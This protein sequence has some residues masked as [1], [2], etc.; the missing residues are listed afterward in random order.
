MNML[1]IRR[2]FIALGVLLLLLV[3]AAVVLVTTFDANRYKGL[4][5]DW[6]KTERQRTL[7]IDGPI[8]LSVFPRLAIKVSKVRL[9]EHA[10]KDEFLAIDEAA[11]AVE[12]LP[13]LR[14]QVVVDRVSARG[15]RAVY[16]RDAKGARNIDDLVG[17]GG[18]AA[19]GAPAPTTGGGTAVRFDVSAVKLD[20]VQLRLRDAMA[21]LDGTVALQSFS[22]GRLANQAES[23]VSLRAS[24]QLT[25]PQALKAA[26][27]GDTKLALDL[28]KNA[29][30][31]RD[32]KLDVQLD[33]T[34]AKNLALTATGAL[35]W[36]GTALRAGPLKL[37]LKGA[38]FGADML[39][40]STLE[41]KQLLFN[42]SGQRLE[43]DALRVALAGRHGADMPFDVALDWPQLAVDAQSLKGSALS[44]QVKT[45]GP[46]ALTG[47]FRSGAPSGKFEALRL[48]GVTLTLQGQM[49]QRKIDGTWKSD[50]VVNAGRGAVAL[51]AI[52]LKATLSDPGLQPLQL[53]VRGKANADAKAAS[54]TLD[55]ALSGNKFDSSGQAALGGAVPNIKANAR[56]DSLD[57][58][59]VLAPDKPAAAN[60]AA[61][62]GPAPAD[63]PVALDGLNAV[64]GQFNFTAGALAFRQ[65]RVND[66]KVD[67]ALDGG[68]LRIAKL[69][70]RAWGGAIDGSG[71]AEAKSHRVAVKLAADGVDVN[72]L[73]K[74]VAGK[75]LLEGTGRVTADV[76][77]AGATVGA[78]RSA[79]AGNVAL[80]VRDGAVKGVNLARMLRQ[81]KAALAMKTDAMTQANATEKTDFSELSATAR[82]VNGVATSD[83]LDV[84]S[85]FLRIGG[86]GRFDIGRG[87][88]DYTAKATVI[89]SPTGQD[90]AEL[91][92]LKGVTVP[93]VLSGP[94]DA[95]GWKI[96][97][98]AVA[99][100]VIENQVKDKLAERL[101]LKPVPALGA[102]SAA[103][104]P[105]QPRS[106]KDKMREEL[107]RLLGK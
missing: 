70:G 96:Q 28:D 76:N 95:I 66:V 32:M 16:T 78:M 53:A 22:S 102:A 103:A 47:N 34:A 65:Y 19:P 13:L 60:T 33:S 72:A 44:G 89:G 25:Q 58:N 10:R 30:A 99:G 20:D 55:G 48:P 86:A 75:D 68:T 45:S 43:L 29:V 1:W 79:L 12:V 92:A 57:L 106:D 63:T 83:D 107:K 54:W 14:K 18:P 51:D 62:T 90:G 50:V 98:S 105:A 71:S 61:P 21:K 24:V 84:K 41:V 9:S 59:K 8:E 31:L 37:A 104:A 3:I 35:A 23:P 101:G 27:D 2:L 93:V 87:N 97:W 11:L 74:N 85:P 82:I 81:A 26:L 38:T 56:F 46:I 49:Q 73:L 69:A 40:A 67:A 39:A 5:I 100:K 7:V 91:A 94:F 42:T 77:T 36:D 15:V 88:V 64:N 6:M 17:T 80:H 52:D 4:A